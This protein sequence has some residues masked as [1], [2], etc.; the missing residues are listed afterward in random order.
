MAK[1]LIPNLMV[2]Y[3]LI[4]FGVPLS[5]IELGPIPVYFIDIIAAMVLFAGRNHIGA[6]YRR[7]R[8]LSIAVLLFIITLL[9]TTFSELLRMS[10]L[11]PIYLL[12]RTLL[13]IFAIWAVSGFLRDETYLKKFFIGIACGALF[14]A[15]V[16]TLNSLPGSG[17]WIR[18]H[19]FTISWLKPQRETGY[20]VSAE[21]LIAFDKGEAERGDSLVGKSNVTG[22]VLVSVLPFLIGA[23]RNLR[24]SY[25]ARLIINAAIVMSLLGLIFTYSRLTYLALA[26]LMFG[27]ILFER[28]AFSKRFLPLIIIGSIAFGAVG[29]HS[30]IFKFDFIAEKFDLTN[31]KYNYTNQARIFAYTYPFVIVYENPS[32]LF[33]GAGRADKKLREKDADATILQLFKSEMHSVFAASV[34]Y[35]GFLSM[36]AIFYLYFRFS[37]SSFNAY[38]HTKRENMPI[39]WMT[40]AS[41]ISLMVVS[42]AWAF[43]HYLVTKMSAHMNLFLIF[44]M[45]FTSLEYV[46]Q[47]TEASGDS[48]EQSDD[49]DQTQPASQRRI[50]ARATTTR[51]L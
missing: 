48:S 4:G 2:L 37:L 50:L 11:E 1:F 23:I 31:E 24:F 30:A 12:G 22:F 6:M 36:L 7:H 5:R 20:E 26:I 16:A 19:V 35:R 10:P 13:H 9:P 39:K 25:Q 21:Q 49:K 32:Y 33:R 38:K 3:G 44:A 47:K 34:F 27:Y 28:Q 29:I 51:T 45:V 41:M 8:K 15:T 17:P 18:A 14:T 43:D 40:I 42:P 46:R